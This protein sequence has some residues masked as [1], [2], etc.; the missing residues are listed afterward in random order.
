MKYMIKLLTIDRMLHYGLFLVNFMV[1]IVIIGA[2]ILR[3]CILI[4]CIRF[5]TFSLM[6]LIEYAPRLSIAISG[7]FVTAIILGY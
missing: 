6:A 2:C 5:L 7:T 1:D 3:V 4:T